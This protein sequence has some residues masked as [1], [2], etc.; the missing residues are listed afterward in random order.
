M[1]ESDFHCLKK[2]LNPSLISERVGF[3]RLRHPSKLNSIHNPLIYST[4]P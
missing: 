3:R 1:S 4:L 2:P